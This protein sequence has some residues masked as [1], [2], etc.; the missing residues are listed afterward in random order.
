[1]SLNLRKKKTVFPQLIILSFLTVAV[2]VTGLNIEKITSLLSRAANNQ[3]TT[4]INYSIT[5]NQL[6]P[7]YG[8]S[9]N[10][11]AVYPKEADQKIGRQQ[12]SQPQ[13]A[14]HCYQGSVHVFANY[15]SPVTKKNNPDGTIT[16]ITGNI[17][18]GGRRNEL[19]WDSGS[20]NCYATLAW[21]ATKKLIYNFLAQT[22]FFVAD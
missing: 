5:L 14:V 16:G 8:D 17:V 15:T 12:M 6:A 11:T 22:T 9:V 10:F 7:R 21:F 19:V 20:A 3:P 18:L 2:F 13:I 4:S 1:M